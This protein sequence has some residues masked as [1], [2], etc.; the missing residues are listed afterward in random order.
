MRWGS[1]GFHTDAV[2]E[3]GQHGRAEAWGAGWIQFS[4]VQAARGAPGWSIPLEPSGPVT[5]RSPSPGPGA[6]RP[7]AGP[8]ERVRP[9]LG[10]AFCPKTS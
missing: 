8:G 5:G 10:A 6:S 7:A 2:P 4:T 1:L 9:C 3:A